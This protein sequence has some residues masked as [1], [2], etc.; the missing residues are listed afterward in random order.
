MERHLAVIFA[1]LESHSQSWS[2]VPRDRMVATIGEYRHL[3]ETLASQFGCIY[4][5]WA[6]DGHM[7]LFERPDAAAQF[8]LKL[9]EAWREVNER[10]AEGREAPLLALRLGCHF[11]Q[12]SRM[13]GGEGWIGRAN[14]VAKRVESCAEP[15]SFYV[16]SAVLDLIDLP[17]YAFSEAGTHELKGDSLP[18]RTLYRLE[19]FD[20]SALERKPAETLGAEEWF[21]RGVALIGTEREWSEEEAD[22]YRYAIKSRPDYAEAHVNLAVVLRAR[23]DLAGAGLHYREALRVRPEN[24]EAHYNYAMLLSGRGNAKA[25]GEHLEEA[26]RL[27]PDYGDARHA[28]ANLLTARGDQRA[29][30]H[31]EEA[32]RLRPDDASTH[33][34]Y[35]ILLERRGDLEAATRHYQTAL[36]I[37]PDPATHYNYA[38]SL[39]SRG[40]A[41]LAELHYREALRLWPG[42]GEAHNNLAILLQQ[43]GELAEAEEHYRAALEARPEDPEAHYNYALLLRAAERKT[44]AE[45]HFR[46]AHELAP[47]VSAFQSAL[48]RAE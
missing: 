35:A 38:L 13:E 19:R 1:D 24:P 40:E 30:E 16:T 29:A 8:G 5:E 47:D 18:Q 11:G 26:L 44:D 31:Y 45:L 41:T 23:G 15:T 20:E 6:G 14:V 36:R 27:R 10:L 12:C 21:L 25:A 3:A 43:R 42:Y 39:D 17:L 34:D 4:R 46:T 7:F 9:T 48:E 33:V 22:C 32:L 28:Y 37:L 2:S